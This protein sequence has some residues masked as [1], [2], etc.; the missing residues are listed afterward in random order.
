MHRH[1]P[2]PAGF[3]VTRRQGRRKPQ[4]IARQT[5]QTLRIPHHHMRARRPRDMK[6]EIVLRGELKGQDIVV[7]RRTA[8]QHHRSV[9]RHKPS[10]HRLPLPHA[11]IG[12]MSPRESSWHARA[13]AA[14]PPT[15]RC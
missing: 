12:I 10:R 7:V 5:V 13:R 14:R 11:R 1:L 4:R 2:A 3:G 8:N 6:P 9:R 15:A